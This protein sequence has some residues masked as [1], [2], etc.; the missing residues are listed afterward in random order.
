MFILTLGNTNCLSLT[1]LKRSR[2]ERRLKEDME[3][4]IGRQ[5]ERA[6]CRHLDKTAARHC[7]L[8]LNAV[9]SGGTSVGDGSFGRHISFVGVRVGVAP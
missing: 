3:R 8:K 1:Y 5:R 7:L 4:G 2:V 9:E 6:I